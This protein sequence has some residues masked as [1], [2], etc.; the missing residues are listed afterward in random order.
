M[1][2]ALIAFLIALVVGS[3]WNGMQ[4]LTA[5]DSSG[6]S[7]GGAVA[8]A[9]PLIDENSFETEVTNADK[10]VLVDFYSDECAPCR[11]MAPVVAKLAKELQG[12]VK[13]VRMDR[14]NSPTISQRYNVGAIPDFVMFK[15]GE[16]VDSTIGA[17]DEQ[18]LLSFVQRHVTKPKAAPTQES[19]ALKQSS[20]SEG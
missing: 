14:D 16:K 7:T 12:T 20:S 10:P 19:G 17:Q 15:N 5:F 2:E 9:V 1:K 18:E 4:Q 13:V 3:I 6:G 11:A 8:D